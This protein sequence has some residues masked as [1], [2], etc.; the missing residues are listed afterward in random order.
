[1]GPDQIFFQGSE[2]AFGIGIAFGVVPGS[3][4]LLDVESGAGLHEKLGS[5]LAA[6]V[7]DELGRLSDFT[8]SLRELL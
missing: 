6:V 7:A 8:D 2:G 4:D 1:M 5:R 3:E